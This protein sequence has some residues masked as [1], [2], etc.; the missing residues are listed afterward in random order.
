MIV[1]FIR[2]QDVYVAKLRGILDHKM[3]A[4]L[5]SKMYEIVGRGT[6]KF[7]LDMRHV[8]GILSRGVHV[9]VDIRN[10]VQ[11][12]GGTVKLVSLQRQ[13]QFVLDFAKVTELFDV[14]PDQVSAFESFGIWIKK[15]S[16]P[17]GPS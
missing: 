12:M 16:R 3:S 15:R 11:Q 1:S 6:L 14:Y 10:H 5:E 2:K 9:L 13:A 17:E 4:E 8:K 7:I